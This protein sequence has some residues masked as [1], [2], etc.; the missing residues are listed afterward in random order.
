MKRKTKRARTVQA[1]EQTVRVDVPRDYMKQLLAYG[2]QQRILEGVAGSRPTATELRSTPPTV[3]TLHSI[4][5]K[6]GTAIDK[7]HAL[8][9]HSRSLRDALHGPAPDAQGE[10]SQGKETGLVERLDQQV[11]TLLIGL[12]IVQA[13]LNRVSDAL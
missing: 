12:E 11:N 2:T 5:E 9:S 6:L 4:S 1:E 8:A 13:N 7:T 3:A 10:G